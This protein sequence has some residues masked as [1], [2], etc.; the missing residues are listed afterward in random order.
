MLASTV[1]HAGVVTAQAG[2]ALACRSEHVRSSYLGWL[3]NS[4]LLSGIFIELVGIVGIIY[5]PFLARIFKHMAI[6]AWMW[7]GLGSY[8]LIIYSIEWVRKSLVRII[9]RRRRDHRTEMIVQEDNQ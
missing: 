7:I 1:Y 6:P 9:A 8:A 2:N 3:S 4:Y 5:I